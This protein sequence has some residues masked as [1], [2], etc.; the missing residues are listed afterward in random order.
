MNERLPLEERAAATAAL[1]PKGRRTRE[2]LLK[3][4][5]VVLEERGYFDATV[6]EIASRSD[7]ALGSFYRYFENKDDLFMV[8]LEE[9]VET[10]YNS[11][12]GSWQ[13]GDTATAL[14]E[15]TR[16]YLETYYAERRL[17]AALLQMA[18]AVPNCAALWR[19]LRTR[20]YSRMEKYL[21]LALPDPPGRSPLV[22]S[23]LGTMVEHCA[24]HWFVEGDRLGDPGP[25]IDEAA[26]AL[27]WIWYRAV[28]QTV[29]EA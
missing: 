8:L 4:G 2:R 14:R 7:I 26:E 5:R 10:L 18:A 17:I 21:R 13:A 29:N 25:D 23:A 15:S 16:R 12:T 22:A 24:Y 27:A 11:T 6:G 19:E 3:G 20:T 1:T 9:L 28:Y